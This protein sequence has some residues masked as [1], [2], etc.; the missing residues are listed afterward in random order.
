MAIALAHVLGAGQQR[1]RSVEQLTLDLASGRTSVV[2]DALTGLSRAGAKGVPGLLT[3]MRH[4]EIWVRASALR[5]LGEMGELGAEALPDV[6]AHARLLS[7]KRWY[8]C[9]DGV[10]ALNLVARSLDVTVTGK[11]FDFDPKMPK[12]ERAEIEGDRE[13]E[14]ALFAVGRLGQSDTKRL[15][16]LVSEPTTTDPVAGD[17][18][19]DASHSDLSV[20]FAWSTRMHGDA[21]LPVLREVLEGED[22]TARANA[23]AGLCTIG[24]RPHDDET[25]KLVLALFESEVALLRARAVEAACQLEID[26]EILRPALERVLVDPD[27][28]VRLHAARALRERC[29]EFSRAAPITLGCLSDASPITRQG[30]AMEFASLS[31]PPKEAFV[32]LAEVLKDADP[33]VRAA[34]ALAVGRYGADA[35]PAIATLRALTRDKDREVRA[36][37]EQALSNLKRS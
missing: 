5:L 8:K 6:V 10:L 24:R 32:A 26:C 13:R 34:A 9:A 19:I 12:D 4:K 18:P 3:A 22:V 20:A 11:P 16:E 2:S 17:A 30:A 37:A 28:F 21:A 33:R 36:A 7:R 23:L 35:K 15:L 29:K 25:E 31:N 14:T 27:G 1:D